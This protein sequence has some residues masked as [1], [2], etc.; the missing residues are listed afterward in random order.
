MPEDLTQTDVRHPVLELETAAMHRWLS[1]DP[2]GFL[3]ISAADVVYTDPYRE[4][5]LV[6]REALAEV[7]AQVRGQVF[8]D[9]FA[10]VEPRVLEQGD[11]AVLTFGF[12]SWVADEP[13]RWHCTE[14][15]RRT[16]DSWRIVATHWSYASGP[17]GTPGP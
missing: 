15:Y 3:E 10:F 12:V 5:W 11:I 4:R 2:D 9:R 1:G 17:D 8:A 6:G 13:T 16:G 7:Y 14:V